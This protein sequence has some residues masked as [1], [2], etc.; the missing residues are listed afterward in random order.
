VNRDLANTDYETKLQGEN[1]SNV[2][3]A[4]GITGAV[5]D[6]FTITGAYET[7]DCGIYID[8]QADISI[9]N[10][11][12]KNNYYGLGINNSSLADIH[13]CRFSSAES[14]IKAYSST[15]NIS[16]SIF[17]GHT[18]DSINASSTY[19]TV[20]DSNFFEAAYSE[21]ILSYHGQ[22]DVIG[23]I[24]QNDCTYGISGLYG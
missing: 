8:N 6:G 11:R 19:L 16:N 7:Y 20:T 5:L 10:C 22:A 12:I 13:N 21:A 9:V 15:L 4:D 14:G 1:V 3:T 2:V 24:I 18:N 23:C 17:T